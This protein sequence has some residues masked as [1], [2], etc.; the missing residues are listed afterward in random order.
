MALAPVPPVSERRGKG[1][2]TAR[3][4][5]AFGRRYLRVLHARERKRRRREMA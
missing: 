3:N 4:D 1:K 2:E 5:M